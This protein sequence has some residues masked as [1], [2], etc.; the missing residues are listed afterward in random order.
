MADTT[1]KIPTSYTKAIYK[2]Y[3]ASKEDWDAIFFYTAAGLVGETG[4][5]TNDG[6]VF[7]RPKTHTINGK[8]FMDDN[9][10]HVG[11]T[12]TGDDINI[13]ASSNIKLS[14]MF[15][16]DKIVTSSMAT[17]SNAYNY[18]QGNAGDDTVWSASA[19]RNLLG[20]Y[21]TTDHNHDSV[22]SKQS[23][24][25]EGVY[26]E[27][28][29]AINSANVTE[30]NAYNYLSG[31]LS[32]NEVMTNAAL[33]KLLQ[34]HVATKKATNQA[35]GYMTKEHVAQ[36][37]TLNAL[38]AE[39][40]DNII[41]KIQDV[42]DVF[43]GMDDTTTLISILNNKIGTDKVNGSS[44]INASVNVDN[45]N[46]YIEGNTNDS[47]VMS[48]LAVNKVL[49]F[50]SKTNH[51]HD[52]TYLKPDNIVKSNTA[53]ANNAYNY[54]QGN[55]GDNVVWS[56]SSLRNLL[57]FYSRTMIY[58]GS[59]DPKETYSGTLKAGDIWINY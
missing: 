35:D 18:L 24:N 48:S 25:H 54:L 58:N 4:T 51:N 13:S 39:D 49:S 33:Y 36:L 34:S 56:A 8:H 17:S 28:S 6:L 3:N 37:E 53:N 1:L 55:A 14:K 41:N 12:L 10:N 2:Q 43:T 45:I 23:H 42:F 50:Y 40:E 38:I 57:G 29:K 7:L 52:G 59:L 11:I 44:F 30:T 31:H 9:N 15:N 27:I 16:V 32:D 19:L 5:K 46:S 26:F 22:Y 21:S 20:F 47:N